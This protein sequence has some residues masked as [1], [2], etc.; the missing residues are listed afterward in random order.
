MSVDGDTLKILI[1]EDYGIS[2]QGRWWRSDMHSSL[3]LDYEKGIYYFNTKMFAGGPLDYLIKIRKMGFAQAKEYLKMRGF[4]DT[5]VL[6]IHP[7]HDVIV[8]P[9]LAD[10]FWENSLEEQEI[11]R[12]YWYTR[13]ITDETIDRFHLGYYNG[14]YTIPI[15]QD[16][17]L[18]Q[19][20]LRRDLPKKEI[21]RWYKDTPSLLVNS[22]ILRFVDKI[23]I[24]EGPNDWLSMAQQGLPAVCSDT[25]AETWLDE[26]FYRFIKCKEIYILLDNDSAGD[27]GSSNIAKK[28]GETRC[29]IYNF[30]EFDK[31]FSPA[32]FFR[33]GNTKEDL[34]EIVRKKSKYVFEM[35]KRRKY[36]N[37]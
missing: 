26:W 28:L 19:I 17:T 18:R 37:V 30:W 5:I 21:L 35:D 2:G 32:Y 8:Y 20:Q 31:G 27:L 22:S 4:S 24:V 7:E 11:T 25:G 12:Q 29:K 1:E 23:F 14:W 3:V 15:Y 34:L 36:K 9:K 10:A 33:Y 16:D 6:A 13:K